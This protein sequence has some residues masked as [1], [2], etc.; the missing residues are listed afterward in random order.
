M[1]KHED[2][3][4]ESPNPYVTF[5]WLIGTALATLGI[6]VSLIGIVSMLLLGSLGSKVNLELYNSQHKELCSDVEE[7][8]SGNKDNAALMTNIST[9][10]VLVMRSLKI[11]P[12]PL[13]VPAK[14]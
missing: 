4:Y 14:K 2:E 11:E 1:A 9:N 6:A 12:V 5:K 10:L 3:E 8:K 13:P 7:I